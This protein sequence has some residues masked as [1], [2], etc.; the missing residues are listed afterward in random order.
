MKIYLV[1][2][3]ELLFIGV[4]F[5]FIIATWLFRFKLFKAFECLLY[6]FPVALAIIGLMLY[7]LFIIAGGL[8]SWVYIFV[9]C[10]FFI[11]LYLFSY[12][13]HIP[14][15]HAVV[16]SLKGLNNKSAK[17]KIFILITGILIIWMAY[18][19]VRSAF[20]YPLMNHDCL[21]YALMAKHYALHCSF[22]F[23][24]H[25]FIESNYFYY[26]GLHAP[27]FP[28]LG[29][30]EQLINQIF[31]IQSDL[32]FR[33]LTV[34]PGIFILL[35]L[36]Y[37]LNSI[38]PAYSMT[39]ICALFFTGSFNYLI[40]DYHIDMYRISLVCV[41][42]ICML[43][44]FHLKNYN[45]FLL[46]GFIAGLQAHAHTLGLFIGLI[47]FFWLILL[48][49]WPLRNKLVTGIFAFIL[50]LAGGAVHYI[51]DSIAGTGWLF[52]LI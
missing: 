36:A 41:A 21:E 31:G 27:A 40:Y 23:V 17:K 48:I 15:L 14:L 34:F 2:F 22:D 50:F 6:A 45:G 47:E 37:H 10:L 9:I 29:S 18:D 3:V 52:K 44:V 38:N 33:L 11:I 16:L 1:L 30:F 26:V 32:F 43:Y 49:R 20:I 19:L 28:L 13:L 51:I 5:N 4:I 39:G 24:K 46:F 12:R 42:F 35:V 7:Y 8:P 25:P